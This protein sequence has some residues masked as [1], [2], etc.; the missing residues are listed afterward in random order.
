MNRRTRWLLMGALAVFGF[1][2][3]DQVYRSQIEEPST[4]LNADLDRLT[5]QLQES[6]DAEAVARK[7][8]QRLESYQQRSLPYDP[9]L[10]RSAY[11]KWLLS[12]VDL[13]QIQSASVDAAQPKPVEI[14]SRTDRRKRLIV[15]NTIL[16]SLRGKATLAQWTR[17]MKDFREAGHLHKIRGFA[18]NPLGTEG[19]LDA[20][21]TIEVLSL[22]SATRKEEL[23]DWGMSSEGDLVSADYGEF[24]RRN[25]FARGFAQALFD[26]ELK[27]I[28]F[29]RAGE[30]EAW[31]QLDSRGTMH[32]AKPSG[33]LPL[34]LH[35]IAIIEIQ[36]DKVLVEVN[37][38]PHWIQL[39][40]TI[41][42]ICNA[43]S[44]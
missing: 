23:S 18:L 25:L 34:A 6:N 10:A 42:E 21:L 39:G 19:Q 2:G 40:Q 9:Q 33:T 11:Q 17:W 16:Y 24:V 1:Y 13:H 22:S 8:I 41:G 36:P 15:G 14:R 20:S 28:T 3:L 44:E 12:Q 37:N 5:N 27:A 29:D 31:F 35:D 38:D 4:R 26:V 32:S 7:A 30:P 43:E